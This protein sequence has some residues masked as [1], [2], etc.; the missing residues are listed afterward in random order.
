MLIDD[1]FI[2]PKLCAHLTK[3]ES[4]LT[5]LDI[6]PD[7][8]GR[9]NFKAY[10][11]KPALDIFALLPLNDI[12]A[13]SVVQP[14]LE[15][16]YAHPVSL[17]GLRRAV[18]HRLTSIRGGNEVATDNDASKADERPRATDPAGMV[19]AYRRAME[20]SLFSAEYTK[21]LADIPVCSPLNPE[22]WWIGHQRHCKSCLHFG[23]WEYVKEHNEYNPCY[24]ADILS[25][26][27]NGVLLPFHT[28]PPESALR[29]YPLD[30]APSAVEKE[31]T[32]MLEEGV[33]KSGES[34]YI[35]PVQL[36]IKESD[37]QDLVLS[38]AQHGIT[39][40]DQDLENIDTLNLY[41]DSLPSEWGIKRIKARVC[42]DFSRFVN[43][44]IN[45]WDFQYES[46]EE[47]VAILKPNDHLSSLDFSRCFHSV[48]LHPILVEKG[49]LA[50]RYAGQTWKALMVLFGLKPGPAIACTLTGETNLILRAAGV[51]SSSVYVD[52][53]L[54]NSQTYDSCLTQLDLGVRTSLS[55]GWGVPIDNITFPAQSIQYRGILIDSTNRTLSLPLAK[56]RS[57]LRTLEHLFR[58]EEDSPLPSSNNYFPSDHTVTTVNVL[59]S[60]LGRLDWAT[61]VMIQGRIYTKLIRSALP[62]YRAASRARVKLSAEAN[63]AIGW[64]IA[65]LKAAQD[66]ANQQVW[67][68]AWFNPQRITRIY[69][70]ASGEIGFGALCE[71]I[72]V[73]GEW[74]VAPASLGESSAKSELVPMIIILLKLLPNLRPGDLVI[75]HTDNQADAYALNKAYSKADSLPLLS[76]LFSLASQAGV[77]LLSDWVPRRFL[78]VCDSLSK[79]PWSGGTIQVSTPS[80]GPNDRE[81]K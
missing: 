16:N 24:I 44:N 54:I 23:N 28:A 12:Y 65:T 72:G 36:V 41:I 22:A 40:R 42:Q 1:E 73:V 45:N 55:L 31:H 68:R 5:L 67:T 4:Q 59:R 51:A 34:H 76:Y 57:L 38:L 63:M 77:Y 18:N 46:F 52:D 32:R 20:G 81:S 15:S 25:M 14:A 56:V 53:I 2:K 79:L 62:S 66:S 33:I 30:R 9:D 35:S 37:I 64:W 49:W 58:S 50:Y 27:H 7:F 43:D 60:L 6:P 39:L 26:I 48:P 61:T 17:T 10:S 69:S 80:Y 29:N 75:F 71:H 13:H 3:P 78:Q 70:D 47:N 74:V 8:P 11:F 19:A 21:K